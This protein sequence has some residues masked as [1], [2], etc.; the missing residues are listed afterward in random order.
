MKN[1]SLTPT[2]K[3]TNFFLKWGAKLNRIFSTEKSQIGKKHPK[4]CFSSLLIREMQDNHAIIKRAKRSQFT[5][6]VHG[7]QL[8]LSYK[9]IQNR[10]PRSMEVV[11]WVGG[12]GR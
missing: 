2:N 1:T 5:R 11:N 4:K 8:N 7:G 3:I 9:R 12:T 6:R 10:Y